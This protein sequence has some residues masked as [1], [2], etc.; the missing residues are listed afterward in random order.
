MPQGPKYHVNIEGTVYD[1]NKDT[2]SVLELRELGGLPADLLVIEIDEDNNQ[3]TLAE[4]EI[5]QVKPGVGFSKKVK[6]GRG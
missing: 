3:R 1:W 6:Y 2:I 5:V 4:D